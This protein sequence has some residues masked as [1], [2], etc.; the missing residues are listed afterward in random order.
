VAAK[1][2]THRVVGKQ[3]QK[4]DDALIEFWRIMSSTLRVKTPQ[5]L[6]T[7]DTIEKDPK[8]GGWEIK[9]V[10]DIEDTPKNQSKLISANLAQP[11][12]V[13]A[14]KDVGHEREVLV[15]SIMITGWNPRKAFDADRLRNLAED[16]ERNTLINAITVRP[17]GAT[18]YE[19]VSGERR[20]RAFRLLGKDKIRARVRELT[21]EQ[22]L[23]IMLSENV[24]R[25]DLNPIEE[26]NHLKRV[27]EVGKLTQTDLARRIGKSQEWVSQRLR[28]ADAPSG[29]QEAIIKR[30]INPTS[31]AEL[32]VWQNTEHFGLLLLKVDEAIQDE[33]K[34]GGLGVTYRQVKQII[35]EVTDPPVSKPMYAPVY[36]DVGTEL[37]IVGDDPLTSEELTKC[38]QLIKE[39]T[40]PDLP[41]GKQP[42]VINDD[43]CGECTYY[44]M[45]TDSCPCGCVTNDDCGNNFFDRD[46]AAANPLPTE[47]VKEIVQDEIVPAENEKDERPAAK[48]TKDDYSIIECLGTDHSGWSR[49]GDAVQDVLCMVKHLIEGRD[50]SSGQQY[51]D[52]A[53][54][55]LA[56]LIR[57]SPEIMAFLRTKFKGVLP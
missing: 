33:V 39:I 10:A 5:E 56:K 50:R 19:L 30:L 53:S 42:V 23:D 8:G 12:P 31:A 49:S 20:L 45:G 34:S 57:D 27:L 13:Q 18:K 2:L 32:L 7:I 11:E 9:Y 47:D 29:L 4:A 40:E 44:V 55:Q 46:E 26:A 22:V 48:R 17:K 36:T 52:K 38:N 28:L 1:V 54:H 3:F 16:I 6:I 21:D 35:K 14:P 24:H 37:E 43:E 51:H 15:S 41:W 25:E